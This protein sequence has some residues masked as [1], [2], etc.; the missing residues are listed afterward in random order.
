MKSP[1]LCNSDKYSF[2]FSIVNIPPD[3]KK[4]VS[5][6]LKAESEQF[7]EMANDESFLAHNKKAETII[8]Q[9]I[10]DLYRFFKIH[11]HRE[12]FEDIFAWKFDFHNKFA[13]SKLLAEDITIQHSIAEFNFAKNYFREAANIYE[14]LLQTKDNAEMLQKLAF[15]YQKIGDYKKALN[16]YLK[17]DL[18]DQNKCWNLK[19]IALCYRNLK[20]P[21]KALEYYQQAEILEPDNLSLHVSIGQCQME[22]N[23]IEEALKSYYKVEYL[24]PGNKKI[25]RPIGW[26]SFLVGKIEQAEKYYERLIYDSPNKYDLLNMGHVQWCLGNRKTALDFYKRS[27][28]DI[29]SSEKE[30]MEAFNED[31][32]SLIAHGVNP[33]DVPI[34]LDQLRYSLK[35]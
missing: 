5:D 28:N 1:M 15:C 22:L 21:D 13:F 8:S 20:K 17:A 10:R 3:Y 9:Y 33:D 34:M 14:L 26:C 32:Q 11:P 23:L 19:K 16:Y 27:I 31:L 30:F 2:F 18:F 25:W 24:S 29:E 35:D 4:L 6:S 7:E 12:D